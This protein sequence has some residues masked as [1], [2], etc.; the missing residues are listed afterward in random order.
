MN[1]ILWI[2]TEGIAY[3][4]I[5]LVAVNFIKN[6]RFEKRLL[7]IIIVATEIITANKHI[8]IKIIIL[9]KLNFI[10][11]ILIYYTQCKI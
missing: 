11:I 9:I 1:L 6:F 10:I 7:K 3:F 5:I 2:K 4:M 8:I